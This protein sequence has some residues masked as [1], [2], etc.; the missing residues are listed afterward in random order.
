M[1]TENKHKWDGSEREKKKSRK[2]NW[3]GKK[4]FFSKLED[5]KKIFFQKIEDEQK[6]EDGKKSVPLTNVYNNQLCVLPWQMKTIIS[7]RLYKK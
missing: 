6:D 3:R 2:W 4:F 5:E 1:V 7:R